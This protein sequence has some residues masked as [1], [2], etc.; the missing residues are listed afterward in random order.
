MMKNLKY[1]TLVLI[2]FLALVGCGNGKEEADNQSATDAHD[3]IRIS[4][5]Q[6]EEN[7]MALGT[8]Q[9]KEFPN[10]VK[11]TGMIDVPPENRSVVT[12]TMGGYIKSLPLLVGDV[13]KK[14]QLLLT[15]ENPEFVTLQQRYMEVK[16]QLGY[17]RSEYN[18][19]KTMYEENITSE[20]SYLK[21]ESEYKTAQAQYEGLRKQLTMLNISPKNVEAGTIVSVATVYA[22]ISGSVTKV[23]AVKGSY[24]AP[25]TAIMEIIDNDHIHLELSVFEK[26]I[27]KV[28]KGQSISFKVTEASLDTFEGEVHLV[29]TD[30]GEGRT[31]KVH[32]HLKDEENNE[33]LTG[34]FVEANIITGTVVKMALPSQSIVNIGDK[35]FVLVVVEEADGNYY[36]KQREVNARD[37]YDEFTMI[38]NGDDFKS[39]DQFLVKGA[40]SVL[41]E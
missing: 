15:I 29:G 27:L 13:V 28:K 4:Q 24:V 20:K 5:A 16:G 41:G 33:F 19:Q 23:N 25:A 22:P 3:G 8:L 9:E 14:G 21:A 40:F 38:E 32:G 6:F 30:I 31:I 2:A 35:D 26:D 1:N 7:D 17:L 10:V 36:F 12:A 37:T 18:R 34:M 11:V 39:T